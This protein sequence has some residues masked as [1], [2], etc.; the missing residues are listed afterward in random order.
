MPK[1]SIIIP[2]YNVEKY[3]KKCLESVFNQTYKDYEVIVVNDGTK[4]KSMKIVDKYE[5][6]TIYQENQGLSAARNTGVRY[7]KG[8]YILFLDS[9]DYIAKCLLEKINYSLVNNP[10]IVRFQIRE[11]YESTNEK[12]DFQEEAFTNKNGVEA[13]KRICKYH[14]V[15]N[16][17]AYAIKKKYFID[18]NYEFKKG[19]IHEDFGLIPLVIMKSKKVN[20]ISY[21]GYN[22]LQREGSIMSQNDYEKTKKKVSDFY[23]HY[24]FLIEEINK[25][26]LDSKVFKSFISNSLIIKICELE[27]QDYKEYKKLLKDNKVYDN[28]LTDSFVRKTKKVLFKISPKLANKLIK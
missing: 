21:I 19:T 22:Y 18:N 14:F 2:V 17:W 5:V 4:D 6:T 15:E 26:D 16:A 28:L 25:T 27:G 12:K 8:E 10:D 24:L 11:V 20:S 7:A 3:L 13:F 23:N 1:F 9:D